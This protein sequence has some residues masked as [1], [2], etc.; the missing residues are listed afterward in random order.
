MFSFIS[1]KDSER[2]HLNMC[3]AQ[4]I[5]YKL[6]YL[7]MYASQNIFRCFCFLCAL[8]FQCSPNP[9]E[10]GLSYGVVSPCRFWV[11]CTYAAILSTFAQHFG[12]FV[13]LGYL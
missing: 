5:K 1:F 9:T 12:K 7:R 8:F 10:S 6:C 13:L 2:S 4:R 3:I 11:V